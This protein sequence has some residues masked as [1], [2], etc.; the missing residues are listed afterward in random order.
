MKKIILIILLSFNFCVFSQIQDS[1]IQIGYSFHLNQSCGLSVRFTNINYEDFS[2]ASSILWD[3]GDGE[4][5]LYNPFPNNPSNNN[6][7]H[8]STHYYLNSG[9]YVVTVTITINNVIYAN[10]INVIIDNNAPTNGYITAE[11]IG[12]NEF[13][14]LLQSNSNLNLWGGCD[15]SFGDGFTS[16]YSLYGKEIGDTLVIHTYSGQC[17][18]YQIDYT[19]VYYQHPAIYCEFTGF[20]NLI[21]PACDTCNKFKLEIEKKYWLSGWVNVDQNDDEQVKTYADLTTQENGVN[22]GL[23][24]LGTSQIEKFYPTGDIIEGWQRVVG[25]FT[26]PLN[27]YDLKLN[28]NADHS[29]N[30]YFDDIRIHPFNASMKSYVYD[31]ETFWLTSELDDNNYAT[32]YEYDNEGGLVRI[33]K[34]TARGIVTIQETRSGTVK[35]ENTTED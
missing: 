8:H 24:F 5:A 27:T 2:G 10:S 16:S 12:D 4:T 18:N 26:V 11:L 35:I 20:T 25:Q 14:F 34:E 30:T 9:P 23:E 15:V 22:I 32:F 1:D 29:K 31:G 13:A 6:W 33:K 21:C 3:F 17:Q 7:L 28:L 19:L